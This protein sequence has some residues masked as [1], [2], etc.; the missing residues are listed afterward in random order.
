MGTLGPLISLLF[1]PL[2][3]FFP[4]PSHQFPEPVPALPEILV[5]FSSLEF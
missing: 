5:S 2:W 3:G 1:L 4:G